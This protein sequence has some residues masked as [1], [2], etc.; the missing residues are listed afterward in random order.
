MEKTTVNR[1]GNKLNFGVM[2]SKIDVENRTVG[3][4]ATLDNIDA[5]G[6]VVEADG[7]RRAFSRFR[8]GLR[9][10]HNASSAVGTLVDFE[11][12]KRYDDKDDKVYD[13]IYVHAKV[14]KGAQDT[15]EKV[16]D[17]TYKGFSIGGKINKRTSMYT[18]DGTE[19]GV[20]SDYDLIE[21]SLVDNPANPLAT[22]MTVQKIDD[23]FVF[24]DD[25]PER[26]NIFYHE[27]SGDVVL[28]ADDSRDGFEHIGWTESAE[29]TKK[30]RSA[31]DEHKLAKTAGKP[32]GDEN[33][34]SVLLKGTDS[35]NI[36]I[37]T[38][39]G[40]T[41]ADIEKDAAETVETDVVE[42]EA[43]ETEVVEDADVEKAADVEETEELE[44]EE[45]EK[46]ADVAEVD[47]EGD[48]DEVVS[49]VLAAVEQ[50]VS[51]AIDATKESK[52]AATSVQT[53]FDEVVKN[54]ETKISGLEENLSKTLEDLAKRLEDVE[55]DSAVKKSADVVV[56]DDDAEDNDGETNFW[57]GSGFL[58]VS[59]LKKG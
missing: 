18:D 13:G 56:E 55:S 5:H 11:A 22:V 40:A 51:K 1:S 33:T 54:L 24:N 43:V 7:S 19:I 48:D 8:G 59:D 46:A 36:T 23:T 21:L 32:A 31:L 34:D 6:D 4:F 10:M 53:S 45:V 28:S 57:R 17:G 37:N 14:S 30:I 27:E 15:W 47:V 29:D 42:T 12:L 52:D 38:E 58:G 41:V 2:F 50:A 39:G 44:T 16:L 20:I 35:D 25:S 26:L 9:E 3:G 49:K